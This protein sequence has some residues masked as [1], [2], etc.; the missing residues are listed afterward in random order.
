MDDVRWR[1]FEEKIACLESTVEFL[2]NTRFDGYSAW[3]HLRRPGLTWEALV[4]KYPA[5]HSVPYRVTEQILNDAKYSGYLQQEDEFN[6]R[7]G[8]I[9][10]RRIPDN[11]DYFAIKHLRMEAKEAL[12][13]VRPETIE[14]AARIGAIT[15]A[16]I[17]VLT[18]YLGK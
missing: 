9:G 18:I 7:Q 13:K 2:Q 17:A 6:A 3:E 10:R 14:Q 1:A 4:E 8:K 5:L 16:D 11:I 12:S 15:P